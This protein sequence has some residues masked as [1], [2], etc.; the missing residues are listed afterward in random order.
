MMSNRA[1]RIDFIFGNNQ[2]PSN[3]TWD[4]LCFRCSLPDCA[5]TNGESFAIPTN[6]RCPIRQAQRQ[7]YTLEQSLNG[8]GKSIGLLPE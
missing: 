3:P 6:P 2:A 1:Q 8:H 4:D 7:G 5:A